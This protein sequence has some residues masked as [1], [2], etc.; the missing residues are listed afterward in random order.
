MSGQAEQAYQRAANSNRM[1][2]SDQGNI[3]K[4]KP[5][6]TDSDQ[7]LKSS[8]SNSISMTC[9]YIPCDFNEKEAGMSDHETAA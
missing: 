4:S 8:D 5:H 2:E 3:G 1:Q 6:H 7:F 9:R